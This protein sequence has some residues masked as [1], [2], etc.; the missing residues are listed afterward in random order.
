MTM[1]IGITSAIIMMLAAAAVHAQEREWTF[2]TAEEDA[3]LSFGVP[4]TDDLGISFWCKMQSGEARVFLPEAGE[5][6]KPSKNAKMHFTVDG[7]TYTFDATTTMNEEAGVPSAEATFPV[8]D[9]VFA[10]FKKADRF[11]VRVG[12][13]EAVFPL[14]GADIDGFVRACSPV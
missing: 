9:K 12:K 1:R 4:E 13:D 5:E 3:Y 11:S 10:A 8:T 14:E 6:V 7:T 2:D